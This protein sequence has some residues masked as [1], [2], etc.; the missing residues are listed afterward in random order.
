MS[1]VF[2]PNH[3]HNHNHYHNHNHNHNH[4]LTLNP[5]PSLTDPALQKG[6]L[7][8]PNL[9]HPSLTDPALQKGDLPNPY[10]DLYD[11]Y[12]QDSRFQLGGLR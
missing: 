8:N 1:N 12:S 10:Y 4:N 3:N 9:A 11:T 6:D 2:A 7:P 5:Y